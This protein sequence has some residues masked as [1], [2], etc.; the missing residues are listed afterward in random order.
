[1]KKR[2]SAD[3]VIL[4]SIERTERRKVAQE[5]LQW[6]TDTSR[7]IRST[8]GSPDG[9][10]RLSAREIQ[11]IIAILIPD[12][13]KSP[14]RPFDRSAYQNVPYCDPVYGSITLDPEIAYLVSLPQL[15][16]LH[17]IRQLPFCEASFPGA[18]HSRFEHSVGTAYV[19]TQFATRF[20]LTG[21][22]RTAFVAAALLHD[23]AH[24]PF[25]HSLEP[26][27]DA[28]FPVKPDSPWARNKLDKVVIDL[29]LKQNTPLAQALESLGGVGLRGLVQGMLSPGRSTELV[30][31]HPDEAYVL[32]LLSSDL[33]CDRIDY[34]ARDTLHVNPPF[35]I[36]VP[37]APLVSGSA[38]AH[39]GS[40]GGTQLYWNRALEGLVESLLVYRS[41]MYQKL[42]Q[43]PDKLAADTMV[44]HAVYYF[45]H[46][47]LLVS[48]E[49]A[50]ELCFLTDEALTSLIR[51][52]GPRKA[53]RLI[54]RAIY[55]GRYRP[56][57]TFDAQHP[58][59]GK[60][61]ELVGKLMDARF[62]ERVELEESLSA[63]LPS[64]VRAEADTQGLPP[65]FFSVPTSLP[66]TQ[67]EAARSLMELEGP[68]DKRRHEILIDYGGSIEPLVAHRRLEGHDPTWRIPRSFY[69]FA[70][71][72]LASRSLDILSSF[73]RFLQQL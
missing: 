51:I 58:P 22:L 52:C 73:D 30:K 21:A 67:D 28:L 9:Q 61:L 3:D 14:P 1:M 10:V 49:V 62:R 25:G 13:F 38:S 64:E 36:E 4:Q 6:E 24:G 68:E 54:E 69:L 70:L 31:N 32:D 5:Q 17:R 60:C 57:T 44:S 15:L 2:Q 55:G 48:S 72:E 42:Y 47:H 8:I 33:D 46:D 29:Y 26:V 65:V 37:L 59:D 50:Q 7:L 53:S 18:S 23:I 20:G 16:R 12:E 34:L 71:P 43:T 41:T 19:A 66:R 63:L 11:S 56:V 27:K 39:V 35:R 45:L 40:I